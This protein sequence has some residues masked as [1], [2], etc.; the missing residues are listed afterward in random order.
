MLAWLWRV[1]VVGAPPK[2][3][4][5]AMRQRIEAVEQI[6]EQFVEEVKAQ[7][8]RIS[9]ALRSRNANGSTPESSQDAPGQANVRAT[10]YDRP[11][12]ARGGPKARGNY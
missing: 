9:A 7:R 6:V 1:L 2:P 5:T 11:P 10:S 4:M 8:G 12:M 3:G